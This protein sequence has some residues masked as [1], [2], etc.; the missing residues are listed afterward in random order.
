MDSELGKA[1]T[2]TSTSNQ[3]SLISS[4]FVRKVARKL[5]RPIDERSVVAFLN[6]IE[7]E[8]L[9]Q[10]GIWKEKTG[11]DLIICINPAFGRARSAER[12]LGRDNQAPKCTC[13]HRQVKRQDKYLSS[14][15]YNAG[16]HASTA[17]EHIG[18]CGM[19]KPS[20]SGHLHSW[21]RKFMN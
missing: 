13:N 6:S 11:R 14:S 9:N 1:L 10:N 2:Q 3:W 15:D 5:K 4:V 19:W 18:S 16:R 8:Q 7:S 21:R 12:A 20:S 17:S